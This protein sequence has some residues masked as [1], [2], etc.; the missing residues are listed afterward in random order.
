MLLRLTAVKGAVSRVAHAQE[1]ALTTLLFIMATMMD[2]S[3]LWKYFA[4]NVLGFFNLTFRTY[5]ITL[6]SLGKITRM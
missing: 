5:Q 2:S 1:V 3:V 6:L 4:W